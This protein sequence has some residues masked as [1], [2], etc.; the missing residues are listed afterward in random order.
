MCRPRSLH[1][2]ISTCADC[3]RALTAWAT[4]RRFALPTLRPL[5]HH[6]QRIECKHTRS[7]FEHDQRIDL[8]LGD[9]RPRAYQGSDPFDDVDQ[10]TN[11]AGG[12]ATGPFEQRRSFERLE[13]STKL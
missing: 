6:H 3:R 10:G 2:D 11:V 8:D 4:A 5:V 12:H 9:L 1:D 13:C 7:T